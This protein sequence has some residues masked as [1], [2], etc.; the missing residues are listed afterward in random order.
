[1]SPLSII[2][3][4]GLAPRR[5]RRNKYLQYGIAFRTPLQVVVHVQLCS[6]EYSFRILSMLF[7]MIEQYLYTLCTVLLSM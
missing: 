4:S 2:P 3:G 7:Y 5:Y 6:T 1:M